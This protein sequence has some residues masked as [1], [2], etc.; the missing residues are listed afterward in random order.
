MYS[1]PDYLFIFVLL[2]MFALV[3]FFV[4]PLAL[5]FGIE[6]WREL[7]DMLKEVDDEDRDPN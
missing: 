7:F 6:S 2:V 3:G 5:K 4:A 1:I